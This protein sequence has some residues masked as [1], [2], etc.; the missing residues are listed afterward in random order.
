MSKLFLIGNGF[1]LS[2][3]LKTNYDDF[4]NFLKKKYLASEDF[5]AI[6]NLATL[7]INEIAYIDDNEIANVIFNLIDVSTKEKLWKDFECSLG[8]LNFD[9]IFDHLQTGPI[10]DNDEKY[11]PYHDAH[12][13]EDISSN[14]IS[15]IPRIE[16][17]F[18]E[19]IS[20]IRI[21]KNVKND[22]FEKLI[23]KEQDYFITFNYTKTLEK[24][25]YVRNICHI[26][27]TIGGKLIFGHGNKEDMTDKFMG[28]YNGAEDNLSYFY[29]C[30]RKDTDLALSENETF[31]NNLKTINFC[32]IYSFGF[33]FSDIDL[34]YIEYL[35]KNINTRNIVWYLH[36]YDE[37]NHNL[38][39]EKII[40]CGYD[41]IFDIFEI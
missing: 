12:N 11:N 23:D 35:C 10:D 37:K 4:R 8:Y 9:E 1:D 16:D 26:H 22:N 25:Y 5:Y 30:L 40:K 29:E 6:T 18:S 27:G 31:L 24:L 28:V 32:S 38:I 19:W 2:H 7:G 41:G 34:I 39:K 36:R 13:R 14:F 21:R 33:S 20:S 17:F 3:K 15:V